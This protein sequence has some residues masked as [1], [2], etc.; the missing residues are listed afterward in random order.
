MTTIPKLAGLTTPVTINYDMMTTGKAVFTLNLT[1]DDE[2]VTETKAVEGIDEVKQEQASPL[3]KARAAAQLKQQKKAAAIVARAAGKVKAAEE[4]AR[5]DEEHQIVV[6]KER[7]LVEKKIAAARKAMGV[8][9]NDEN[10]ASI[11]Q[12]IEQWRMESLMRIYKR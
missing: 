6:E 3:S 7:L 8:R 11:R 9:K 5:A 12:L 1:S 2:E 4:Q 10:P